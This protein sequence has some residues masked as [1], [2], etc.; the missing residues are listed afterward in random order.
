MEIGF[1]GE[2]GIIYQRLDDWKSWRSMSEIG[3]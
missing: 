1:D 3:G 2:N